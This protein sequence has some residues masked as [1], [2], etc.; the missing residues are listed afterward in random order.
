MTALAR[1][2]QDCVRTVFPTPVA[3]HVWPDSDALNADLAALAH[4]LAAQA[5]SAGRSNV[6]GWRSDNGFLERSEPCVEALAQ[7]ARAMVAEMTRLMMAPGPRRYDMEGWINLLRAGDY[8]SPHVHPN[9]TWSGVYYVAGAPGG[10][11]S[12]T[13]FAGKI[14]LLDPRPGAAAAYT[15]E[16]AM[17]TRTLL[18][19]QPGAML[20]FPSWLQ[21]QVHPFRG[22]GVRISVAFNVLV[23]GE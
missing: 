1:P 22:E 10:T 11:G 21:H 3:L 23:T 9:S 5:Q 19:P 12:D 8:N 6:G 14:E 20:L 18:D 17:Q 16:N 15:V 4:R 13:A 2:I 7:R